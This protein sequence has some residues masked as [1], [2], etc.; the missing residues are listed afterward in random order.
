MRTPV[1]R[2]DAASPILG[3]HA[4]ID[5]ISTNVVTAAVSSLR[6]FLM[7]LYFSIII[8]IYVVFSFNLLLRLSLVS[9]TH[10][11]SSLPPSSLMSESDF[12]THSSSSLSVLVC[13]FILYPSPHVCSSCLLFT[14]CLY[15]ILLQWFS[16]VDIINTNE[17]V[18][19]VNTIV[20]YYAF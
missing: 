13:L 3:C 20:K 4:K 6:A 9:N 12:S 1:C 17:Y 5:Q 10:S 16:I 7:T 15:H 19:I 14:P 2:S 18:F 8:I 11:S